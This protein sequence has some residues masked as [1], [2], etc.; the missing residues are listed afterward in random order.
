MV[1][2]KIAQNWNECFVRIIIMQQNV[3][4]NYCITT[5][6]FNTPLYE[7]QVRVHL[8][9]GNCG[10]SAILCTKSSFMRKVFFLFS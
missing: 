8:S 7:G 2:N 9:A 10:K 6:E 4:T 1:T 3:S 5:S